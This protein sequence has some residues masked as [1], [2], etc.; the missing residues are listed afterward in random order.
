[1][2]RQARPEPYTKVR[3]STRLPDAHT[4]ANAILPMKRWKITVLPLVP[5]MILE[6]VS[7]PEWEETD[8]S[9][10][11]IA[12]SGA[13]WLLPDLKAKFQSNMKST[14]FQGYGT[15]EAVRVPSFFFCSV[16]LEEVHTFTNR[17]L[18]D[19]RDHRNDARELYSRI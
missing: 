14:L 6:M 13:A 10:I 15:S 19:R 8:I 7:S 5:S 11:E 9:T 2:G 12:A 17:I 16:I 3:P 4:S 18:P 1:M